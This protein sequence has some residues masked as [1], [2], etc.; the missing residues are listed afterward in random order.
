MR[1]RPHLIDKVSEKE[2]TLGWRNFFDESVG[3]APQFLR[4]TNFRSERDRFHDEGR[5]LPFKCDRFDLPP[6]A[7]VTIWKERYSN[8]FGAHIPDAMRRWGYVMWDRRRMLKCGGETIL[9]SQRKAGL[10]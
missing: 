3:K 5:R 1:S 4:R 9:E 6:L 10:F 8:R 7:W 2:T